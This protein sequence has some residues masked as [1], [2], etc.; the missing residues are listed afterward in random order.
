VSQLIIR[1]PLLFGRHT[2]EFQ[3]QGRS[4]LTWYPSSSMAVDATGED[5][6]RNKQLVVVVDDDGDGGS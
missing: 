3:M 4:V 5:K 2:I 6:D 1:S